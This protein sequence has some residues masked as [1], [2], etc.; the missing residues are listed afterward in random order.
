MADYR[1]YEIPAVN[2]VPFPTR[3]KASGTLSLAAG[4]SHGYAGADA[5]KTRRQIIVT[6]LSSTLDLK[7]QT[8]NGVNGLTVFPRTALTVETGADVIVY[9]PDGST[10]VSYEVLEVFADPGTTTGLVQRTA[11]SPGSDIIGG[12]AGDTSSIWS[13]APVTVTRITGNRLPP[14]STGTAPTRTVP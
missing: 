14:G 7:L 10:A 8:A 5:G 11:A 2:V 4:E 12:T 13:G 6:N 1:K 3:L 9:N